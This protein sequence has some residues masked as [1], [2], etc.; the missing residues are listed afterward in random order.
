MFGVADSSLGPWPE[1]RAR[2]MGPCYDLDATL[3]PSVG[4]TSSLTRRVT[5]F[6]PLTGDNRRL[7]V[8]YFR[9]LLLKRFKDQDLLPDLS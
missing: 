5:V 9:A 7:D 2:P 1:S 4:V 8:G 3:W 6:K